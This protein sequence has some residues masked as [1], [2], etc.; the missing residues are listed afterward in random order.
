MEFHPYAEDGGTL[1]NSEDGE[2]SYADV[3][4]DDDVSKDYEPAKVRRRQQS[5]RRPA[6]VRRHQQP[7]RR[8]PVIFF[9]SSSDIG[10]FDD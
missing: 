5:K 1:E 6:K 9:T 4:V 8:L 2:N 3:D 10:T 7:K